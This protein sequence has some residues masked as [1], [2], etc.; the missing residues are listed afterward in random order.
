MLLGLAMC[1][2]PGIPCQRQQPERLSALRVCLHGH[3]AHNG[4]H[5]AHGATQ[6]VKR[7]AAAPH[8]CRSTLLPLHTTAAPHY[9][10]ST[11]LSLR[12]Q[13]WLRSQLLQETV[14]SYQSLDLRC[15]RR[16][17]SPGWWVQPL[18]TGM[19]HQIGSDQMRVRTLMSA[20]SCAHAPRSQR[21]K[22]N[23]DGRH[24][25]LRALFRNRPERN[26]PCA[27][28][29]NAHLMNGVNG[30]MCARYCWCKRSCGAG[31][32]CRIGSDGIRGRCSPCS[33]GT[34]NGSGG[35]RKIR[36]RQVKSLPHA[37]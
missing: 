11:P 34:S 30:N 35:R 26:A 32:C 8:Y 14:T 5:G 13:A 20:C 31:R 15:Q 23:G 21:P 27:P 10:R 29:S 4:S 16:Q 2:V 1:T 28:A 33:Q 18:G 36:L 25:S 17:R 9:C 7:A 22:Q 19:G 12:R 24:M 3:L 6:S 37:R